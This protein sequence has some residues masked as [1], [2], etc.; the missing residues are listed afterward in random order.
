[1]NILDKK[2][3]GQGTEKILSAFIVLISLG[4]LSLPLYVDGTTFYAYVFPRMLL[5]LALVEAA[6]FVW[7]LRFLLY[8]STRLHWR[9]PIIVTFLLY[10]GILFVS[11]I[12]SIDSSRS[13]WSTPEWMMGVVAFFH[14]GVWFIILV[15]IREQRHWII[16]FSWSLFIS[17]IIGLYGIAQFYELPFTLADPVRDGRIISTIGNPIYLAVYSGIHLVISALLFVSMKNI[18]A[19]IILSSIA[20]LQLFV[21]ALSGSRGVVFSLMLAGAITI[22]VKIFLIKHF[23]ARLVTISCLFL[24]L[25]SAAFG[26]AYLSSP[27]GVAVASRQ[28]PPSIYRLLVNPFADEAR[29]SLISIGLQGFLSRPILGWGPDSYTYVFSAFVSPYQYGNDTIAEIDQGVYSTTKRG[30]TFIAQWYDRAHNQIIEVLATTGVMGELAFISFWISIFFILFVCLR[31]GRIDQESVDQKSAT[32]LLFGFLF[33][34]FQSLAS[35]DTPAAYSIFMILLAYVVVMTQRDRDLEAAK[36]MIIN[37]RRLTDKRIFV[38]GVLVPLVIFSIYFVTVRPYMNSKLVEQAFQLLSHDPSQA[39]ALL[40]RATENPSPFNRA[41]R[42]YIGYRLASIVS[43][44]T[45]TQSEK[46]ALSTFAIRQLELNDVFFSRDLRN[47]L[48]LSSLYRSGY[49]EDEGLKRKSEKLFSRMASF[50][51]KNRYVWHERTLTALHNADVRAALQYAKKLVDLDQSRGASHFLLARVYAASG[52]FDQLFIELTKAKALLHPIYLEGSFFVELAKKIPSRYLAETSNFTRDGISYFPN[53]FE[54][55]LTDM[56]L[57][58]RSGEILQARKEYVW[59]M[60]HL[61]ERY[62]EVQSSLKEEGLSL[63]DVES[64]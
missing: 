20:G 45:L 31:R 29:L 40:R 27:A 13:F 5:F 63:S 38:I 24:F 48:L 11:A 60:E 50:Y 22:L 3:Y 37:L 53:N 58:I 7:L 10:L 54:F 49:V 47:A 15:N 36:P 56:I 57:L 52:E 1:M 14:F 12:F 18:F 35:F 42:Y 6:T 23:V 25:G 51:P 32:I 8:S 2:F 19:R 43:E 39:K 59:L 9:H 16:L 55:R 30:D 33:Y 4:I 28:L 17:T 44:S 46:S 61:P 34:L 26:I 21:I 62:R 41:L 64:P